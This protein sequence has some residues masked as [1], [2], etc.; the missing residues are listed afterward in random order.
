MGTM[1]ERGVE[2]MLAV[3]QLVEIDGI[4]VDLNS[5]GKNLK[6]SQE[7]FKRLLSD[8][9]SGKL[10]KAPYALELRDLSGHLTKMADSASSLKAAATGPQ[11]K[12]TA[13]FLDSI[14]TRAKELRQLVQ[15][16]IRLLDSP[17]LQKPAMLGETVARKQ[18]K[19]FAERLKD[20]KRADAMARDAAMFHRSNPK[21]GAELL[22]EQLEGLRELKSDVKEKAGLFPKQLSGQLG[23]LSSDLDAEMRSLSELKGKMK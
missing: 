15:H 12:K 18:L 17:V 16:R 13:D 11:N 9:A 3:K 1:A 10:G 19:S 8:Y 14:E 4:K 6:A 2:Q 22:D 23:Q 5:F 21:K 7:D 20:L